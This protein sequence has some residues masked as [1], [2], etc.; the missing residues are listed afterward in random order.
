MTEMIAEIGVNW[1][2]PN[3]SLCQQ[4]ITGKEMIDLTVRAVPKCMIKLQYFDPMT[5]CTQD[6]RFEGQSTNMRVQLRDYAPTLGQ[7]DELIH[8]MQL[9][10]TP[11][12][13][14]VFTHDDQARL[15][16]N[17]RHAIWRPAFFKLSSPDMIDRIMLDRYL[18]MMH[19]DPHVRLFISTGG[20]SETELTKLLLNLQEGGMARQDMRRVCLMHCVA[21]YPATEINLNKLVWLHAGA[22]RF[23]YKLGL[24]SHWAYDKGMIRNTLAPF[25]FD[26]C[27][28]HV[29]MPDP[30]LPCVDYN[31]SLTPAYLREFQQDIEHG[32]SFVSQDKD[33]ARRTRKKW[34]A[35]GNI[36]MGELFT[37]GNIVLK[38]TGYGHLDASKIPYGERA[39]H[40]YTHD[41]PIHE[42][43]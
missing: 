14:T 3:R 21:K 42:G 25:Q 33:S 7:V 37:E 34:V 43:S 22:A 8:Y 39:V 2:H 10:N 16:H 30:D 29:R 41:E 26:V 13:M 4:V 28:C 23:G 18:E 9:R 12:G 35:N 40:N 36:T 31:V 32:A 38:R 19:E 6:A 24:S 5:L 11:W 27:E 1:V 20:C 17:F 15:L